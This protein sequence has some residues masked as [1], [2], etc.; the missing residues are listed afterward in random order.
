M[1]SVPLGDVPIDCEVTACVD[2]V[3][4]EWVTGR[5]VQFN[6]DGT[7][8]IALP[9]NRTLVMMQFEYVKVKELTDAEIISLPK[10]S[11]SNGIP[12]ENPSV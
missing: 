1:R 7:A 5:L 2:T 6:P 10:T 4:N 8:Y 3:M 11:K 12:E 9:N